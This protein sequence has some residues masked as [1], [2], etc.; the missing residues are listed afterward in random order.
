M[1]TRTSRFAVLASLAATSLLACGTSP[2]ATA[3]SSSRS[4]KLATSTS[5]TP[6][7][8]SAGSFAILATTAVTCTDT[9]IVGNVGVAPGTS[10]TQTSCPVT[11]TVN[12][13][14]ATATQAQARLPAWPTTP[15][16][17]MPCTQ[18]LTTLDG[19]TLAP[20]V[21]CFD[22]AATSTG[23]VLTLNGPAERDPGSSR[24]G[25]SAPAP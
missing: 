21:Y 9:T 20:G 8:G 19:L 14:D 25:P 13:G 15:S 1:V 23:G 3:A 22:A 24:S 5:S 7:F 2:S 18:T 6:S 12:A 11:G 16:R 17:R 4:A 10:I